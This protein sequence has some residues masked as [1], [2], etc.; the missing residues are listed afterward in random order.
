MGIITVDKM[1]HL[2]WLGRYI[3]RVNTSLKAYFNVFDTMIDKDTDYYKE[4]CKEIGIPDIYGSKEE[5]IARYPY[6]P[7]DPNSVMSNLNRAYDNAIVMRDYIGTETMSYVQ[8]AMFDIEKAKKS[9]E[10][11]QNMYLAIDHIFAFW[12]C[13]DDRIDDRMVKSI[14]RIGKRYERIDLYLCFKKPLCDILPE[15]D[16][17]EKRLAETHMKHNEATMYTF[18]NMLND[19]NFNYL[20]ARA[21]FA[22][23]FDV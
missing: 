3:E 10:S 9:N 20:N 16:R 23:L 18:K 5:F 2:F 17:L 14:L 7:T 19:K 1:D 12:G 8:L 11:Y 13:V 22:T 4:V 15:L 6:D 21:L